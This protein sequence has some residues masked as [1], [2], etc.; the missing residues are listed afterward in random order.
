MVV[1]PWMARGGSEAAAMNVLQA[2]QDRYRVT[3]ATASDVDWD[4]LNRAFG[5]SVDPGKLQLIKSPRLPMIR[6][7]KQLV[8]WQRAVF[9]RFCRSISS[10]FEICVSAYNPIDFG[11]NAVQLIGDFSFDESMRQRLYCFGEEKAIRHKESFLRRGYLK[12]GDWL[13][14]RSRPLEQR[15]DL[16]LANS[17]WSARELQKFSGIESGVLYPPVQLPE[18]D[19]EKVARDPLQFVCLGRMSPEKEWE[20]VIRILEKVRQA[21]VPVELKMIGELGSSAYE[22]E[23][24]EVIRGQRDWVSTTGFLGGKEK[25]KVIRSATFAIHGCRIEAFGIA[26]AEMAAMGAVP[27]VPEEGGAC[28]VV[29][30]SDLQY[31][32]EDDAVEKILR[33]IGNEERIEQIRLQLSQEVATFG[34]S[35]FR[36]E[37]LQALES[38]WLDLKRGNS[39][40]PTCE[41]TN[42]AAAN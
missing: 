38:Q 33:L 14:G 42:P 25:E 32:D 1:H 40:R 3:F 26:V 9:E 15:N 31:E 27:F 28:E 2:L 8:H 10:E 18:P 24:A 13:A 35:R 30:I 39:S 22:Q 36:Q 21:G 6:S 29:G 41:Q 11:K 5:T 12:V 20:K 16:V 34:A 17:Q 7:E 4:T 19:L 23:L 37:V